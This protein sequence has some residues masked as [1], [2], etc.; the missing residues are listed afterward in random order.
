MAQIRVIFRVVN[1]KGMPTSPRTTGFL[2]Y[3]QQFDIVPQINRELSGSLNRRGPY[4][5][6][7]SKM[8]VLKRARRSDHT[9]KG[10]VVALSRIRNLVELIPRFGA[11]ADSRLSKETTLEYSAEFLLDKFL[12]KEL[13][14]AL[15]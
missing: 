10:D 7:A 8:F 11:K 13:Y 5:D 14:Y 2:T 4:P 12:D 3:M 1:V 15:N 6:P 9:I